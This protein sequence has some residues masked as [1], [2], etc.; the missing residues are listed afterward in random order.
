M[1]QKLH[2]VLKDNPFIT[3]QTISL[4]WFSIGGW[5][6]CFWWWNRFHVWLAFWFNFTL[7]FSLILSF[8]LEFGPISFNSVFFSL[9]VIISTTNVKSSNEEK[10]K[11]TKLL[12]SL[13]ISYD[14]SVCVSLI[15]SSKHF[16]IP[17]CWIY[18]KCN[19]EKKEHIEKYFNHSTRGLFIFVISSIHSMV[20]LLQLDSF[21]L[22]QMVVLFNFGAITLD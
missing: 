2:T 10:F 15:L 12:L 7:A 13:S 21:T 5:K 1:R 16:T 19:A 20:F 6:A 9:S 11:V 22:D 14:Q 17:S 18:W 4:N 3:L 8:S